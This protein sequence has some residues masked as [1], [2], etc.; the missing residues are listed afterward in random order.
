MRKEYMD[1]IDGLPIDIGLYNIKEYPIHWKDSLRIL[2]V[3]KGS[4]EVTIETETYTLEDR[5]LEIINVDEISSLK[6]DEDNLVLV[7]E[8]EQAYFDRYYDGIKDTYFYANTRDYKVQEDEIYFELRRLI[9]MI[10]YEIYAEIDDYKDIIETE[11]VD[12]I[13]LLLN[14]FH[15]LFYEEESLRYDK[16]ELARYSRIIQ[17]LNEN[18]M[19]KVSLQELANSEYLSSQY[20]SYKIKDT[21]GHSFND[22]LNKVRIEES[23]KLLLDTDK[24]ISEISDEVGFSHSRYYNKHFETK[25]GLSPMDYR[26]KY[27]IDE[28]GYEDLKKYERQDM[29]LAIPILEDYLMDYERFKYD[30]KIIK[31]YIDLSTEKIGD[32]KVPDIIDLGD[33]GLFLEE[34]NMRI[35]E[36]TQDEIG[37]KYA[38]VKNLFSD[39]MDIYRGKNNRFINWTRVENILEFLYRLKIKPVIVTKQVDEYI[40]KDFTETFTRIY[41]DEVE[42]W[43]QL[44][45]SDFDISYL[46]DEINENYDKLVMVP[47]VIDTYFHQDKRLV[48]KIIDEI[49]KETE[50]YN[51]T[52]FGG[53]GLVT[54]N[55]LSK[56]SYYGLMILS[57]MGDEILYMEEGYIVTRSENGYQILLYNPIEVDL[58]SKEKISNLNFSLNL[59]NMKDDYIVTKYEINKNF[60]SVYDKWKQLGYPE[61]I[62][63]EHWDLL[64]EFVHPNI[65]FFY[66][67]MSNVYNIL[68]NVK[69]YGAIL[70]LLDRVQK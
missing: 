32:F 19:Y 56:P 9:S 23:R 69:S 41:G 12:L 58:N 35:L 10:T 48:F 28:D 39:D 3:L 50:L 34:E 60:G 6:S 66:G 64:E 62:S 68:S 52:F 57:L 38:I 43:I 53:S 22:F 4:L 25:Y 26:K 67:K 49:T 45:K 65:S 63:N 40:L 8:M 20:L 36:K 30:N 33:I 7:F 44:G 11:M 16:D 1:Y 14:E 15:Y 27:E 24:N 18:Y 29:K 54:S 42:N 46:E 37:F 47:Y 17:Y 21:F 5:E 51:D 55:G 13:F 61:R 59:Q 31:K 2:F 70:Y